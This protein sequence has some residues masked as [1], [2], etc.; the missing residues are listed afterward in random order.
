MAGY[1]S[2]TDQ[3]LT[4]L[5]KEGDSKAF[6]A[7]YWKYHQAIYK[8]I[9]K[10]TKEPE[11]AQD[12]L[13]DTFGTLWNK[14]E[15]LNVM[16][17][18]SG[19]LFTVSFNNSINYTKKRLKEALY[20]EA[21]KTDEIEDFGL[22]NNEYQYELLKLALQKLSPQKRKVFELCKLEG[23]TYEQTAIE[24]NISKHTVK[25]YLSGAMDFVKKFI[26]DNPGL[27]ESA[28]LVLLQQY[29]N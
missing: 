28:L 3:E 26:K 13:Q 18:V 27:S 16:Q 21:N 12:I 8:N 22:E 1:S 20:A 17:E 5:L 19:W 25:E 24:M 29:I 23:K 9:L 10:L 2:Y 11:A 4:A 14:R 15:S 7:L 6:D